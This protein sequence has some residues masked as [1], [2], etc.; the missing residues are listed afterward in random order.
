[1]TI[2][3]T[4]ALTGRSDRETARLHRKLDKQARRMIAGR[5]MPGPVHRAGPM[6]H[7][8][9]LWVVADPAAYLLAPSPSYHDRSRRALRSLTVLLASISMT[10]VLPL[11][12]G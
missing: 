2:S 1:M 5:R 7:D 4:K 8:P 10:P 6:Y 3:R 12:F 9:A 11:M